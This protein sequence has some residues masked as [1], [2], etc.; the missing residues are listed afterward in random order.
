MDRPCGVF[1]E[2]Y[3]QDVAVVRTGAHWGIVTA[4]LMLLFLVPQFLQGSFLAN[5]NAVFITIISVLGL[6]I[7]VGYTG[8]ISLGQAA[9]MSV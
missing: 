2:T 5:V 6:Q 3:T 4:A 1:D 9:F 7:I 8:Q